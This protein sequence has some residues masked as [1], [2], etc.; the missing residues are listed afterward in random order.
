MRLSEERIQ[1][2]AAQIVDTLLDDEHV[3]LEV[4]EDRFRFL[5]ENKITELLRLEDEIDEEAAAW[6]HQ[7]KSYLEDGTPEFEVELEKIKK[8]L[9]DAKGYVLY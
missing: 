1:G 2:I 8:N 3:D 7:N 9:A 4:A 6:I 5:V